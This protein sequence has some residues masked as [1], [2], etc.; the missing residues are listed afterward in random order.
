MWRKVKFVRMNLCDSPGSKTK[1]LTSDFLLEM[2]L[3]DKFNMETCQSEMIVKTKFC[4]R[5]QVQQVES[6]AL[7]LLPFHLHIAPRNAFSHA[8]VRVRAIFA[9]LRPSSRRGTCSCSLM[10]SAAVLFLLHTH[11]A[12]SAFFNSL[13]FFTFGRVLFEGF[14]EPEG[15]FE[16][17]F[18][19]TGFFGMMS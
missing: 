3:S 19:L 4:L 17:F 6:R 15:R 10:T 12:H 9:V 16:G 14:L 7:L 13:Q 8:I 5:Y 2:G 18:L 1:L 11:D